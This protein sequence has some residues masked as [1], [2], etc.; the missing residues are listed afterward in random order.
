MANR[1]PIATAPMDGSKVMVHW[2]GED[3]QENET[4][5][6]Y[7]SLDRLRRAGGEWDEADEGWWVFVDG[8][9]QKKVRPDSW[10]AEGEDE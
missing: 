4:V 7:R 8:E 9:T 1:K 10:I 2:T 3:G 5:G 6:Q